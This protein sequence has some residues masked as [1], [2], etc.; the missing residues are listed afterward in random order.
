MSTTVGE[1]AIQAKTAARIRFICD[2]S[3]D[4]DIAKMAKTI[5]GSYSVLRDVIRGRH[6]RKDMF[7]RI[8]A[9]VCR[10]KSV[11]GLWVKTGQGSAFAKS[12]ETQPSE[13]TP[14]TEAISAPAPHAEPKSAASSPSEPQPSVDPQEEFDLMLTQTVP[15]Q[16]FQVDLFAGLVSRIQE[17]ET[18][19]ARLRDAPSASAKA[20]DELR[21]QFRQVRDKN[22]SRIIAVENLLTE[23]GTKTEEQGRTL[24][25]HEEA[26]VAQS[27]DLASLCDVIVDRF[28]E[29]DCRDSVT[30]LRA[31]VTKLVAWKDITHNHFL[32]HYSKLCELDD[33][34]QSN[35]AAVQSLR[36]IVLGR[37][38]FSVIEPVD[39]IMDE[40]RCY[41]RKNINS[42]ESLGEDVDIGILELVRDAIYTV[43]IDYERTIG[44]LQREVRDIVLRLDGNEPPIPSSAHCMPIYEQD[45]SEDQL[46]AV[47]DYLSLPGDLPEHLRN[48]RM[49]R[50]ALSRALSS[51]ELY[52]RLPDVC[53]ESHK[54]KRLYRVSSY[55]MIGR[56]LDSI[57]W[58]GDGLVFKEFLAFVTGSGSR[59]VASD[60]KETH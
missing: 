42:H 45:C 2:Q 7:D 19:V 3:F 27:R 48:Y 43:D 41:Y 29:L 9:K 58:T 47:I 37:K 5:D 16:Q 46:F 33:L 38:D 55:R 23:I 49:T 26:L 21:D 59:I 12:G 54:T 17:L 8:V 20:L 6:V 13:P 30:D 11:H 50:Q 24:G 34:I 53:S 32:D 22:E 56:Y 28:G 4:G 35:R 60:S 14:Q 44:N 57:G 15:A 10:L 18:E 40:L 51:Y 36:R 31:S 52:L 25:R 39:K 1:L